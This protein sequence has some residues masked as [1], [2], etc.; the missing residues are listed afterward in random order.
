MPLYQNLISTLDKFNTAVFLKDLHG[1]YL[2]MNSNGINLM[3]GDRK[4][5]LGKTSHDLFDIVSANTMVES[6][7]SVIR[8]GRVHT[9]IVDAIDKKTNQKLKLF[10][11]K[12]GVYSP[13]GKPLG[14][15]GISLVDYKDEALFAEACRLLP[16]FIQRRQPHLLNELLELK[17]VSDFYK[18]YQLH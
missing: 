9:N 12:T 2:S 15:V 17:T 7:Q 4:R 3:S 14:V 5:V 8:S 10:N 13:I 1:H 18:L 11:V 6:D 16:L